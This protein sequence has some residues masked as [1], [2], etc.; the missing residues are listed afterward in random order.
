MQRERLL[1]AFVETG[2]GGLIE[3][4]QLL[5]NLGEFM[6]GLLVGR[7]LVGLLQLLT[8]SG[9]LRFGQISDNIFALMPL[10]ALYTRVVTKDRGNRLAKT[11]AAID[12]HQE[13]ALVVQAA[14]DELLE[15]VDTD[16]AVFAGALDKTQNDFLARGGDSQGHHHLRVGQRLAIQHE[17]SKLIAFQATLHELAELV[18]TGMHETA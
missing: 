13:A 7:L 18:G 2:H 5:T 6:L 9:L 12:D 10:A 16:L 14:L 3:P 11:L 17:R 8:H 4:R 1:E 15:K